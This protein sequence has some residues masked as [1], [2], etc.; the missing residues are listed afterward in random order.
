MTLIPYFN[1][2]SNLSKSFL[3]SIGN[4]ILNMPYL[5]AANTF[6]LTPPIL[7]TWPDK[8]ISPVI[9]I[10]LHAGLLRARDIKV[11]VIAAPADGPYLGVATPKK[12]KWMSVLSR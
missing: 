3:L 11:E 1:S 5:L 4:I 6:S 8:F 10:D 9:A 12:F 2:L 7:V